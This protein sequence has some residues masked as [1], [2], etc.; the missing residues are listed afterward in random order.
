MLLFLP[1]ASE[2]FD[3]AEPK[4]LMS[5]LKAMESFFLEDFYLEEVFRY[6]FSLFEALLSPFVPISVIL[7]LP[8]LSFWVAFVTIL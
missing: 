8:K 5:W 6:E 4:M 3:K 1:A 7:T 2:F